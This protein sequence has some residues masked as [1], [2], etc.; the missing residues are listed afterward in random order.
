MEK[1]Y[2][3]KRTVSLEHDER[4]MSEI[5][6]RFLQFSLGLYEGKE[7][8]SGETFGNFDW[9]AFYRFA[10]KQTLAG[11]IFE[12]IQRLPKK[13]APNQV[14]LMSWF[15]QSQKIYQRNLLLN[16]AAVHISNNIK[17][18]GFRFCILCADVS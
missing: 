5:Y 6:F 2:H 12:G 17:T 15:G 1:I 11:V 4:V 10:K 14:L 7:F 8:L 16:E 3:W 9:N 18:E 13:Y